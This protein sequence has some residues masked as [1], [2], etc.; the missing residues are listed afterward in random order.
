[1]VYIRNFIIT[2]AFILL[3]FSQG[4]SEDRSFLKWVREKPKIT[5]IIVE[6]NEFFSDGAIRKQMYSKTYGF[7]SALRRDRRIYVQRES[8]GRDTLEIKYLYMKNGLLDIGVNEVFMPNPKD[9]SATVKVTVVEGR[10]YLFGKKTVLG[11]YEP[12][13][14]SNFNRI[15][16]Q[17][18]TGKVFDIF[19]VRAAVFDM[20][21]L[22]ANEGYPYANIE[23][24]IDSADTAKFDDIVFTVMP[25]SLVRFGEVSVSGSN[26]F[27]EKA[28]LRELTIKKGNIYRRNDIL[29]SQTRL[30]ESGYF[31]TIRFVEDKN[32][33][34]RLNPD[35]V[36]NLRERK[37][38]YMT[39]TTGAGQSDARD[40]VWNLSGRF[41]KRNF[42]GSRRYEILTDYS[43]TLGQESRL[44][45]HRYRLRY[46]E[47]WFVGI[48]MPLIL[49]GEF[50][51]RIKDP[52]RELTFY[53]ESWATSVETNRRFGA[54]VRTT[55]GAEY[56]FVK[57]SG[58]PANEIERLKKEE[59]NSARR[60]IYGALR[61]DS[62]DDLFVPQ[63]GIL[64]DLVPEY[65]GGF[66]GGD[67]NFVKAQAS[68]STYQGIKKDFVS[69]TRL[70][71]GWS[72]AF[73]ETETV[74]IDEALFL[75]GANSIRGF[76]EK[77]LGPIDSLK[78]VEGATYTLVLNQE[79]RWKT[80]QVLSYVPLL[81]DLFKSIPLWQSVF[82]DAGNGF[83]HFN[84]IKIDNLAYGYGTGVQ[85]ISPAG[86]I[87]IDYA[88]RIP[89]TRYGVDSRWHFTILYAF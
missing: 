77:S 67:E 79:F 11:N 70:K 2:T 14:N 23:F 34:S 17:L 71:V 41:G 8:F 65:F 48:R 46:T 12:K 44:I 49:T 68:W 9:S 35:F 45:E 84:E 54:Q 29:E 78:E 26:N 13:F 88:R 76:S 64:L 81:R 4:V 7:W 32:S 89:T 59:G 57:I 56:E 85:F 3:Q 24:T 66:L 5:K 31:T 21:T 52:N 87:R 61:S 74:P 63:R 75:G 72:R 83:S 30:L 37:P 28:A 51:P 20:K 73:A 27:P 33:E 19:L 50:Q 18:K 47:P 53:R 42:L 69:A 58:I 1:M 55:L 15:V 80:V 16:N 86:P 60:K 39:I 38:H 43:F 22:M 6:G 25:D 40:L 62:R 82:F 10:Q 36:L